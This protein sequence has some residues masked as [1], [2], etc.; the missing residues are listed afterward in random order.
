MRLI[1]LVENSSGPALCGADHTHRQ[2][3]YLTR[4]DYKERQFEY[5]GYRLCAH[6]KQKEKSNADRKLKR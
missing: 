2:A 6:C 3:I 1:H 5:A 4:Q